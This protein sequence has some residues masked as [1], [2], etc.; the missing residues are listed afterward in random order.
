LGLELGL[1]LE[2][3]EAL[4]RICG[5]F[6]I[7]AGIDPGDTSAMTNAFPHISQRRMA[8]L[9]YPDVQSLDVVGPLQVFSNAGYPVEIVGVEAGPVRTSSGM[10]LVAERG[11]GEVVDGIDTLLVAGGNGFPDRLET[12]RC[13]SGC[14]LCS[15]VCGG[16]ARS[17]P[18][19]SSWRL[20]G[21]LMD[22]AP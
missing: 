8:V 17:A 6:V 20:R 5:I 16:L 15:L 21:C 14:G 19:L 1:E 7:A 2:L 13:W 9:A 11:I 10:Q 22:A 4:G 12:R 18:G 3:E